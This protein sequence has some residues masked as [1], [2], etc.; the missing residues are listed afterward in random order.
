MSGLTSIRSHAA[1]CRMIPSVAISL[2]VPVNFEK[3]RAWMWS[4][5]CSRSA[6]G[7]PLSRFTIRFSLLLRVSYKYVSVLHYRCFPHDRRMQTHC[8]FREVLQSTNPLRDSYSKLSRQKPRLYHGSLLWSRYFF[9]FCLG[10]KGVRLNR[11]GR[12]QQSEGKSVGC[13]SARE[14]LHRRFQVLCEGCP[15]RFFTSWERSLSSTFRRET[16]ALFSPE[17][18]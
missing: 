2:G 14:K 8:G 7:R 12:N 17:S 6:S 11:V 13:T 9:D 18:E 4:I 3:R 1:R 5:L 16:W 15:G 10:K